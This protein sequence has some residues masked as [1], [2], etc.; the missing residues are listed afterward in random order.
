[1]DRTKLLALELETLQELY[2]QAATKLKEALL[3]GL[4]WEEV[5]ELR[6]DLTD[7]EIALHLKARETGKHPSGNGNR[8]T[9]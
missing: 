2:L 4:P 5:Q 3:D 7:L 1:M 8:I 9:G 6:H